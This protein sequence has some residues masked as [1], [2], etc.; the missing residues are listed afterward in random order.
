MTIVAYVKKTGTKTGISERTGKE[1]SRTW[2]MLEGIFA[3]LSR[4]VAAPAEG[5]KITAD[6]NTSQSKI[7]KETG[8]EEYRT[9]LEIVGWTY[10][11]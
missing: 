5:R 9:N 1:W 4:G 7:T 11:A 3:S 6:I 8:E 2:V 10:A